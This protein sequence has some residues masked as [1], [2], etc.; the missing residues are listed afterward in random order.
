MK[1]L[2]LDSAG[3]SRVD[4]EM[5]AVPRVG[6]ELFVARADGD[7]GFY[8]VTAVQFA[9]YETGVHPE[10]EHVAKLLIERVQL[11]S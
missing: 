8:R 6:D 5:Q 2:L 10:S 1:L 7:R 11:P 3:G 9:A 4:T